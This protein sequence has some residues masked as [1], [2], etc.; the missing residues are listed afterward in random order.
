MKQMQWF[1]GVEVSEGIAIGAAQRL[2]RRG[3]VQQRRVPKEQVAHELERLHR[4][5]GATDEAL[6]EI[7]HRMRDGQH[8][9]GHLVLEAHRL[10]L[11]SDE[12]VESARTLIRQNGLAAES[13]VRRAI[14]GLVAAF[15]Q[16]ADPYL[17]QRGGDIE[18][19]GDRL[20]DTL[21]GRPAEEQTWR[22]AQGRIGVG[23]TLS[24][25]DAW[26][27]G[28]HRLSGLVTER[29]SPGSHAAIIVRGLAIP[30]VVG[31]ARLLDEVED[32]DL[33]IVDG[34]KG[35]V[36]VHPD[37]ET[38]DRYRRHQAKLFERA[39]RLRARAGRDTRTLD[40]VHITLCANVDARADLAAA[41][42]AGAEAVGLLRTELLYLN[43][44]DLP[45]EEEQYQDAVAALDR[46]G[47]R[48]ATFR[49]LDL[50][51]DKIPLSVPVP[52]A[53]NPALGMRAL[54]FSLS[55][56][57]LFRTQL[58]AL[59][60]AALHG[61]L[62]ILFPLVTTEAELRAARAHCVAVREE[63]A[64][65]GTPCPEVPLGAML[66]TPS[67]VLTIDHLAPHCDFF[68]LGTN[69]LLQLTFAA[70]RENLDVRHLASPFHPATLRLIRHAVEGAAAAG[71]RLSVCGE[72][73]S[74]PALA[75]VLLGLGLEELS[76]PPG[77]LPAVR[78][79]LT[80]SRRGQAEA[81]TRQLLEL[82]RPEEIEARVLG[83][84][85]ERFAL[86]LGLELPLP[87]PALSP[88]RQP[89]S[90]S[91]PGRAAQ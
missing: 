41:V 45:S 78:S 76:M 13:A 50:G 37:E 59:Y 34:A 74:H 5:I 52:D 67:A 70:D 36:I 9:E 15:E 28:Q 8:T 26:Q 88:P 11:Q 91:E 1:R 82:S 55:R 23:R 77:K 73:A 24:P 85:K 81:V 38:L 54:R 4:A 80:R 57:D 22:A 51:G 3:A 44:A 6:G 18:A 32:G 60:R 42:E 84:L 12:L 40:G 17:R 29:G 7:S 2:A 35:E 56:P 69:D 48:L 53:A 21:L 65:A 19:L 72:L 10:M 27:L 31:V 71:R 75:W 83:E 90:S 20:V 58:R 68:S 49:T 66:E 30:Y 86:E 46:L 43:R 39:Q 47:G 79:L 33:L 16:V 64:A 63:L 89:L 62:R 87:A 61:P 14:D 25:I